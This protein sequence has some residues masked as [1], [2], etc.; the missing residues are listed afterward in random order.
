MLNWILK[1]VPTVAL[2]SDSS[3]NSR[4]N[5]LSSSIN[6]S[7]YM[8]KNFKYLIINRILE[9]ARK[10]TSKRFSTMTWQGMEYLSCPNL[11][12]HTLL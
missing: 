1:N 7:I 12:N 3:G 6:P 9:K 4:L 8:N 2:F 5:V 11:S 10:E